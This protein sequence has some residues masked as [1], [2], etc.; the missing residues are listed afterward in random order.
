[1]SQRSLPLQLHSQQQSLGRTAHPQVEYSLKISA[2]LAIASSISA[3]SNKVRS[4][5]GPQLF[6]AWAPVCRRCYSVTLFDHN[7]KPGGVLDLSDS[8]RDNRAAQIDIIDPSGHLINDLPVEV[9]LRLH[10]LEVLAVTNTSGAHSF[11]IDARGQMPV[12]P[13]T[14]FD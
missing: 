8:S 13:P 4:I 10:S 3:W 12:V 1:M 14:A 7:H 11:Q 5:I 9:L 6:I 2:A